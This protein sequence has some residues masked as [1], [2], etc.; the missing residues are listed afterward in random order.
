MA[1][2]AGLVAQ[3]NCMIVDELS[4]LKLYVVNKLVQEVEHATSSKD[5]IS[6]LAKLGEVDGVDAFKK[7]SEVT[8]QIKPMAEVEKELLEALNVLE[9]KFVEVPTPQITQAN[10]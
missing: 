1:Y 6:A 5:R 8:M 2:L 4:D 7:R 9:A 10:E 3:T